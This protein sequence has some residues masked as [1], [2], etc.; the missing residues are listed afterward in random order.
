MMAEIFLEKNGEP[1]AAFGISHGTVLF[2][3]F[4]GAVSLLLFSKKILNKASAYNIIRWSLFSLLVLS[5]ISYQTYTALNGIWSMGEHMFFHLCGVAGVTGAIALVNHHKQLIQITFFIG[6]IPSLLALV[7][8]ELPYDFP[9]YRYLKFFI[10]HMTIS[11]TSIFLVVSHP[12]TI[13]FHAV[14]KTYMYLLIYAAIIGFL[15]NPLLGSNYLYLSQTPT[16][17]TPLDLLGSGV[18]YYVN[19]CVLAF[20]VFLVQYLV[21][22]M[23]RHFKNT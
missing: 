6:L 1:F 19:L 7:T 20:V 5:E 14:L 2:F 3:Y 11:W 16:A 22:R 12:V 18:W 4:L 23:V 15:V 21:Y 13:S 8:P 10:H 17:N 9:H